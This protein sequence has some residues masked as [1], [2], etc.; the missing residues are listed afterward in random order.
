MDIFVDS[1]GFLTW[2]DS[3]DTDHRVR[4]ALGR[5]GIGAK[6]GEGDGVTPTGCYP[7][8]AV[9]IRSDRIALP[10]TGLPV[11]KICDTDGWCD[12]PESPDYNKRIRL[13]HPANYEEL[14][15]NDALYD[16]IVEIG[17]NDDP[18][19]AGK[20]S[21]IFIHI[22][23]PGYTSTEGCVALALEDLLELLAGCDEN[24]RLVISL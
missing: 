24:S 10:Q 14:W 11:S 5:G 1:S 16:V 20:G 22:A 21:A 12:D 8:R 9:M 15:R 7:L 2:K 19:V 13:P 6:E 3:D 18:V 23:R 4:C 17:Y